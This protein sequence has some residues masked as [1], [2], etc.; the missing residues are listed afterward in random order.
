VKGLQS[1]L[2]DPRLL[3]LTLRLPLDLHGLRPGTILVLI[4][5]SSVQSCQA[6]AVDGAK[7]LLRG[8]Q[9]DVRRHWII[10]PGPCK[11]TTKRWSGCASELRGVA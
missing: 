10:E 7:P 6:D 11:I 9:A 1:L 5:L 8:Q 4:H 2:L 3:R